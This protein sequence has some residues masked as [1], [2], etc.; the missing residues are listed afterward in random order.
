M[1]IAFSIAKFVAVAFGAF[2][3]RVSALAAEMA[4]RDAEYIREQDDDQRY[5]V[6]GFFL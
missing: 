3:C 1:S 5:L 2:V 6:C 4:L